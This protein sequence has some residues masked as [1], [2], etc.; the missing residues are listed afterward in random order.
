MGEQ[1]TLSFCT[2]GNTKEANSFGSV[3]YKEMAKD[4]HFVRK[5][6]PKNDYCVP[7]FSLKA[8]PHEMLFL[9]ATRTIIAA[10]TDFWS[11]L[12]TGRS[13]SCCH[14]GVCASV[15]WSDCLF[16]DPR[17]LPPMIGKSSSRGTFWQMEQ[18][19]KSFTRKAT[20]NF[21]PTLRPCQV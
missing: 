2:K 10:Y 18:T 9:T 11:H 6:T 14:C 4:T 12:A 7:L 19:L 8:G 3:N 13:D 5:T 1:E 16:I 15:L 17:T 20:R 21:W